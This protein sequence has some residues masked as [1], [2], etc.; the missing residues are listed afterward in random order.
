MLPRVQ[1]L[2]APSPS[3]CYPRQIYLA[4]SYPLG[5]LFLWAELATS[6][7]CH[8]NCPFPQ[9]CRPAAGDSPSLLKPSDTYPITLFPPQVGE[10]PVQQE[11]HLN[12]S[13]TRLHCET[14]LWTERRGDVNAYGQTARAAK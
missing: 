13:E 7:G 8:V 12:V 5:A 10:M 2:Q 9:V 4:R 11:I 14:R 3:V 6:P 1:E